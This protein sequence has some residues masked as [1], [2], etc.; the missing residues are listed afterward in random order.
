MS[1]SFRS[2]IKVDLIDHMGSDDSVVRA[3]RASTGND[4]VTLEK[5]Q[6]LINYLVRENHTSPLESCVVTFRIEAPIFVAREWMRHRTQ[7]YSELSMRFAEASP[8]FY[9]PDESRPLVNKG[10]GA[11]PDLQPS[12]IEG[13]FGRVEAYHWYVYDKAWGAYTRM[14][15][16]GVAT[17]VARNVLPVGTYTTFYATANLNNWFRFLKLRNGKIGAPQ[18]E[19]VQGAKQVESILADI[20]P[21]TVEAW[22][23]HHQ[24][25]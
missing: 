9:V 1:N 10:S 16:D 13:L 8:E 4:L 23:T 19:I 18:W 17:E 7:S 14:L 15:E 12:E 21:L 22:Q 11:H 3:A 24:K 5:K 25:S 20:Y 2:D 6:G